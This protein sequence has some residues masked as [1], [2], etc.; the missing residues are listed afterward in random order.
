MMFRDDVVLAIPSKFLAHFNW[1]VLT[2]FYR[3][4]DSQQFVSHA[5][6]M[7]AEILLVV[8]KPLLAREFGH[9]LA[10]FGGR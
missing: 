5:A 4:S 7:F 6:E 10:N 8:E 2:F 1:T 3:R 9:S